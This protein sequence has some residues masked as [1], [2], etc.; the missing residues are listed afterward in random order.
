MQRHKPDGPY[1]P[2]RELFPRHDLDNVVSL[3]Q[4]S[5][6][7]ESELCHQVTLAKLKYLDRQRRSLPQFWELVLLSLLTSEVAAL[8]SCAAHLVVRHQ[9]YVV[10]LLPLVL[11]LQT[12]HHLTLKRAC[13]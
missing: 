1:Q 13:Q 4:E 11:D 12:Q 6:E 10:H 7:F 8:L 2:L 3:E 9:I 5:N